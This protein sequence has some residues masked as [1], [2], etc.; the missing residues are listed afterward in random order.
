M[1]KLKNNIHLLLTKGRQ[2]LIWYRKFLPEIII[3]IVGFSCTYLLRSVPYASI[4]VGL[5]PTLPLIVSI[6][7][8]LILLKPR[9]SK[10]LKFAFLLLIFSM[11][12]V[13]LHL[14][15]LADTFAQISYMLFFSII[16]INFIR[17]IKE[18]K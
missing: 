13:Y 3:V 17:I 11:P 9:V 1:K 7:L 8:L 15:D 18:D 16:V 4:L 12:L 6:V 10:I 14:T 2:L 5:I